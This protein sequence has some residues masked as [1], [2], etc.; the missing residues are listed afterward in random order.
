MWNICLEDRI[1]EAS[2]SYTLHAG[3]S[4][5]YRQ[6]CQDNRA[7]E[8]YTNALLVAWEHVDIWKGFQGLYGYCLEIEM[9]DIFSE[10]LN[11]FIQ[12]CDGTSIEARA[13]AQ[14]TGVCISEQGETSFPS[15]SCVLIN[16]L[17]LDLEVLN[18]YKHR[19][20]TNKA[21]LCLDGSWLTALCLTT[22][23]M[24]L[25]LRRQT[26]GVCQCSSVRTKWL[27]GSAVKNFLPM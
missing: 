18:S 13:R 2:A 3:E 25:F 9:K 8:S 22:H 5:F 16:S 6:R 1:L 23:C 27:W 15:C 7:L 12:T 19:I 4:D 26:S 14:L 11:L 10:S 24:S 17:S 20:V 21:H